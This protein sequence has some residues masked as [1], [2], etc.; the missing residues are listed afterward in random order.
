MITHLVWWLFDTI[1]FG[2]FS[3]IKTSSLT[4]NLFWYLE[5]NK[6]ILDFFKE[7][8]IILY[9]SNTLDPFSINVSEKTK[10]RYKEIYFSLRIINSYYW[11]YKWINITKYVINVE[12]ILIAH[13]FYLFSFSW[14]CFTYTYNE[15]GFFIKQRG[16]VRN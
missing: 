15:V 8:K 16:W 11:N 3:I 1:W 4:N 10:Q 14:T 2:D 6:F 13:M 12:K 9:L 7:T 5:W